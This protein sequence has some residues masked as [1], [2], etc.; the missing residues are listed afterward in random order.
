MAKQNTNKVRHMGKL[1]R[2]D[3]NSM[4]RFA[5]ELRGGERKSKISF[6]KLKRKPTA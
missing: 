4:G 6:K 2:Q 5:S 3:M 1:A